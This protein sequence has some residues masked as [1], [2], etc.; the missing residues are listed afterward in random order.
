LNYT[1]DAASNR[2]LSISDSE[3]FTYDAAGNMLSHSAP[4]GN[5]T[6]QYDARN[7]LKKSFF[8]ALGTTEL[9][10]GLGQ[11]VSQIQGTA[12]T[13]FAYDEAGHLI[14]QYNQ[15]GGLVAETVWLG[16]LPVAVFQPGG[17]FVV[18]PDHLGAP[19]Q[20]TNA[21]GQVVWLWNHDPF[22]VGAPTVMGGFGYNLR[23]PGQFSDQNAQ[24][25]YNY[26]RDY[27]PRTGRYIES[28]PIGMAGGINTYG[29][30]NNNPVKWVDPL[31]LYSDILFEGSKDQQNAHD[32]ENSSQ[33]DPSDWNVFAHGNPNEIY[34][35]P[36][37]KGTHFT[38][39]KYFDKVKND[40]RFKQ[41]KK[42]K[43][44]SCDAAAGKKS[45]AEQFKQFVPDKTV[46]GA[47]G[48]VASI[49]PGGRDATGSNLQ[50]QITPDQYNGWNPFPSWKQF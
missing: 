29:Y 24:L 16:D 10:N 17:Q 41:A 14:G 1:N 47:D 31:G 42:V 34:T 7:R 36:D 39:E 32:I 44:W 15:T 35:Q 48:H 26:F 40:P 21:S 50:I 33:F 19:H 4:F 30:V 46:E 13:F 2:L 43:F 11:R 8:G 25:H 23:F 6:Y 49:Y 20:I 27:D 45:F 3:T 38:P 28:D 37:G 9:I 12:Q 22:G 18:A 5:F